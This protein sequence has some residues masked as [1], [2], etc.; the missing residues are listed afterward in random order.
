[1]KNT[2]LKFWN[3]AVV[4]KLPEARGSINSKK[5]KNPLKLNE[6]KNCLPNMPNFRNIW[7]PFRHHF[8]I[9]WLDFFNGPL[10][11]HKQLICIKIG[12]KF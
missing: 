11:T 6:N 10:I 3:L 4:N 12:F 5:N 7:I 8:K 1:M 9:K 2:K